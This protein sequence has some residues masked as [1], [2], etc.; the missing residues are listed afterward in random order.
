[1]KKEAQIHQFDPI[2]YPRKLWIVKGC[3]RKFINDGFAE[4]LGEEIV[5]DDNDGNEPVCTVFPGIMLKE[6]RRY[7]YLV[8]IQSNLS[9]G[10]IAHEAVHVAVELFRD[11]GAY[12]DPDNQEPF[13]YLV[14]WIADCIN[15]VK[16]GKFK[17]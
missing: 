9:V 8:W 13:T 2:I 14:G 15:Q 6:T 12:L 4:R 3:G 5:F 17:D 10:D 16:T 1:M 11:M 7:G